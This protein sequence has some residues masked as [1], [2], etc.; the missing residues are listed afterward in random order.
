[1]LVVACAVV[2]LCAVDARIYK[3]D[4]S[5]K[6]CLKFFPPLLLLLV[7]DFSLFVGLARLFSF[8]FRST[9][10]CNPRRPFRVRPS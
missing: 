7:E 10:R 5:R 3:I 4:S 6:Q 1:M 2:S 9:L 8:F